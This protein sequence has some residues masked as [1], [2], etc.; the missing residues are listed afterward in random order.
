VT[1]E[2]AAPESEFGVEPSGAADA[3]SLGMDLGNQVRQHRVPNRGLERDDARADVAH[4]IE[5][6]VDY[7]A[8]MALSDRPG[9]IAP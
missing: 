6:P 7:R 5:C 4:V 1:D 9:D 2:N 3:V 8:T